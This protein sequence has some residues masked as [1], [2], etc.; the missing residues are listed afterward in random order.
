MGVRENR[1]H[2]IGEAGGAKLRIGLRPYAGHGTGAR[3]QFTRVGVRP[4]CEAIESPVK[5]EPNRPLANPRFNPTAKRGR[6][7]TSEERELPKGRRFLR[8][9]LSGE[10]SKRA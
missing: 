5:G 7:R 4:V 9:Y 6:L 1:T 10:R 2:T 8:R 3:A